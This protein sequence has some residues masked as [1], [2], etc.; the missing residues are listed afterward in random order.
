MKIMSPVIAL[1]LSLSCT[2]ALAAGDKME[3][4]KMMENCKMHGADMAPADHQRMMDKMFSSIDVNGDGSLS[5]EEF[6]KHHEAMR[7][8]HQEQKQEAKEQEGHD[9]QATHKG[10]G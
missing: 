5:K 9:H 1:A 6:D 3:H 2:A 8:K 4:G 10:N 7:A